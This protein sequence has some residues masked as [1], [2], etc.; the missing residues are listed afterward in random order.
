MLFRGSHKRCKE[1]RTQPVWVF[2][3]AVKMILLLLVTMDVKSEC[4]SEIARSWNLFNRMLSEVS[5][6]GYKF[7]PKAFV[8]ESVGNFAGVRE[9]F[10]EVSLDS[11]CMQVALQFQLSRK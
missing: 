11:V 9:E 3:P 6:K 4:M 10:G 5:G 8:D 2:H 1:Y 7:N